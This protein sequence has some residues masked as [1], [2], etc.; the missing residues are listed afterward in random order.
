MTTWVIQC[1]LI[2]QGHYEKVWD[3][4]TEL[5]IPKEALL[6]IPFDDSPLTIESK[7]DYLIPYG[8]T[9]LCKRAQIQGMKGLYFNP[10]TFR[11]D[12][13]F[14]NR[15][16]MVNRDGDVMP[17]VDAHEYMKKKEGS[18]FIRPVDDLKF[19]NGEVT[20]AE[21]FA[22]WLDMVRFGGGTSDPFHEI[23]VAPAKNISLEVRFFVVGGRVITGSIYRR[24]GRLCKEAVDNNQEM[25]AEAQKFADGWLPHETVCMDLALVDGK[26]LEVLEFNC[27]NATGFYHHDIKAVVKAATDYANR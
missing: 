6:V 1:N 27:F 14:K 2:N 3:A 8:S 23:M 18:Y 21:D 5:G 22:K 20:T 19:F 16:D 26:H 7:D 12:V 11:C 24:E 10:D 25:M 17:M 15:S 9:S 4:C 13:W